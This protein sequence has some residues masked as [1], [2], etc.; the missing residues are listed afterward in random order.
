M[1]LNVNEREEARELKNVILGLE[2]LFTTNITEKTKFFTMEGTEM[3]GEVDRVIPCHVLGHLVPTPTNATSGT[4]G[5]D[6]INSLTLSSDNLLCN[7][8][9]AHSPSSALRKEIYYQAHISIPEDL[10]VLDSLIRHRHLH[11]TLLGYQSYA[12]CVLSD[13][14]VGT[15]EKVHEF[16]QGM[17]ERSGHVI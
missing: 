12:H 17:Q 13:R 7:T 3:V 8:L 6:G 2:S 4:A 14:M 10:N 1:N 15:P 11:S 5:G 16:L 9:L